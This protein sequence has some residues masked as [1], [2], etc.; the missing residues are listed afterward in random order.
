MILVIA[1]L[2]IRPEGLDDL[3]RA[4]QEVRPASLA[5]EGAISYQVH[6][7]LTD[8]GEIVFV[9][10]WQDLA[11]LDRHF[12]EPHFRAFDERL[13]KVLVGTPEVVVHHVERSDRL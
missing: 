13:Q 2:R 10:E 9:E 7:D 12:T 11:A 3:R 4:V 8:R 5:E 1:R 6:T